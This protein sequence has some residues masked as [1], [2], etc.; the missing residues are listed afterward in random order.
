MDPYTRKFDGIKFDTDLELP[1]KI[2]IIKYI[3]DIVPG[4]G[5]ATA[6]A[7]A[8]YLAYCGVFMGVNAPSIEAAQAV[9][10]RALIRL[11]TH[12]VKLTDDGLRLF[13]FTVWD[14]I[15]LEPSM[16]TA[17]QEFEFEVDLEVRAVEQAAYE[18]QIRA[19]Q[20]GGQDEEE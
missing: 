6:K 11:S 20:Y 9:T 2:N 15:T 17:H 10:T 16:V 14:H 5:L 1:H 18:A 7:L 19:A 3:R 4:I 13:L 8:E 12:G